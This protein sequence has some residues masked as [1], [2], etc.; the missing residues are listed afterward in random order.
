MATFKKRVLTPGTYVYRDSSGKRRVKT[1]T[2][3]EIQEM[4]TTATEML[5]D[6]LLIPAPYG[7]TDDKGTFPLP[8]FKG[9]N[10]D[11]V[12]AKTKEASRWDPSSRESTV[13]T[14]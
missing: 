3:S 1:V 10:G 4:A 14:I 8:L 12:D 9:E 7:H 6:G 5:Q 11:L 13:S 2:P